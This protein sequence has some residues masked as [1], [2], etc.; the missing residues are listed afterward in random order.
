MPV[1]DGL[2]ATIAIRAIEQERGDVAIPIIALTA[3]ARPQ[4]VELSAKVGCTQ[5]LSKPISRHT[6][7]NA[8]EGKP[9][10]F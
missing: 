8:I 7:L 2:T 9:W 5:H 10:L 4:D 6:L 1:M 3:N